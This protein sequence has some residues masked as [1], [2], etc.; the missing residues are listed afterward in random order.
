[1]SNISALIWLIPV[2]PLIGFLINGLGR[3]QLS[4]GISGT[5]GSGVILASFILSVLV[6]FQVKTNG[7]FNVSYFDFIRLSNFE[8]GFEFKIDQLSSIFLLII[9]LNKIYLLLCVSALTAPKFRVTNC[10]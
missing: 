9:R 8:L 7:A 10:D 2:L 6:F 5:I 1:M 3:K 4:K